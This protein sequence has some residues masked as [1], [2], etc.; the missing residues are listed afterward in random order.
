MSGAFAMKGVWVR[1]PNRC[2]TLRTADGTVHTTVEYRPTCPP[3]ERP[4]WVWT[5]HT[6]GCDSFATEREAKLHAR[7]RLRA[8]LKATEALR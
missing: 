8:L 6:E 7:K 2:S 4:W 3:C 5:A 1:G